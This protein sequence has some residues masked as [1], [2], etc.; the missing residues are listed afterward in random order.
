MDHET[1]VWSTTYAAAIGYGDTNVVAK[2]KAD[3]AVDDYKLSVDAD[4]VVTP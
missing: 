2:A 4:F 1:M 3:Q